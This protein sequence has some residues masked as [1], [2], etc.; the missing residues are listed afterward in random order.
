MLKL[1]IARSFLM[2]LMLGGLSLGVPAWSAQV[3][4]LDFEGGTPPDDPNLRPGTEVLGTK[5]PFSDSEAVKQL[6]KSTGQTKEEIVRQM[7]SA[8]TDKMQQDFDGL[9]ITFV[10]TKPT[11]GEFSTVDFA[12]GVM[13]KAGMYDVSGIYRRENGYTTIA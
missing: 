6:V 11:E 4:F 8:V 10:T 12:A 1:L 5:G 7:Q 13:V 3:V 2:C 9:D